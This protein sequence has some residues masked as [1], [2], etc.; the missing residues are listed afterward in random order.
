MANSI[1]VELF[2]IARQR[3]GTAGIELSAD[4]D[5]RLDDVLSELA[6]ALPAWAEECWDGVSLRADYLANLNG[7]TFVSDPSTRVA[8]G[9]ELLILPVDAGG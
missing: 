7:Q 3:A 2:G 6:V 4:S 8:P 5:R 9:D 1:R